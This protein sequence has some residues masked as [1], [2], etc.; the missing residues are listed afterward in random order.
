MIKNEKVLLRKE[1]VFI[2][3]KKGGNRMYLEIEL[4]SRQHQNGVVD[5]ETLEEITD[6]DD[7]FY[8]S[9]CGKERKNG[10][11][12]QKDE[13]FARNIPYFKKSE[14]ELATKLLNIWREYHLND[15]KA[16]NIEQ[17]AVL[18]E[19]ADNHCWLSYDDAVEVLKERDLLV[20][21]GYRYGSNWLYERIPDDILE[22]LKSL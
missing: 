21:R 18:K 16:G 12:C 2:P 4:R 17:Q 14:Q 22:F 1:V 19:F 10:C 13:L 3:S 8:L 20:S 15:M 5:Y 7:I 6:M 11:S 9:I